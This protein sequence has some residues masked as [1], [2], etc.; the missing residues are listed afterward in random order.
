MEIV[1]LHEANVEQ[2]LDVAA[3]AFFVGYPQ[4]FATKENT[5]RAFAPLVRGM[6]KSGLSFAAVEEGRIVAAIVA[7][8]GFHEEEYGVD[9]TEFVVYPLFQELREND[10]L[11][12]KLAAEEGKPFLYIFTVMCLPEYQGRNVTLDL[13]AQL[14]QAAHGKGLTWACSEAGHG[15]TQHLMTAFG[16]Q[17]V[18]EL[19]G[20]QFIMGELPPSLG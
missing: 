7:D 1:P 13:S 20:I 5:R 19:N 3:E 18:K 17:V 10:P 15:A 2:A 4:L 16:G 9:P 11:L 8:T 6:V 14:V 12:Q